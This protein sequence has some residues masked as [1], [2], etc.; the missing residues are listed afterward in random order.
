MLQHITLE[1]FTFRV[2]LTC[3]CSL[4]RSVHSPDGVSEH[5]EIKRPRRGN[6]I[7]SASI[8][9]SP[10]PSNHVLPTTLLI[11]H[12]SLTGYR[13][14]ADVIARVVKKTFA[15]IAGLLRLRQRKPCHYDKE[16][17]R[18]ETQVCCVLIVLSVCLCHL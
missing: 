3:S 13:S 10:C 11:K 1:S 9:N 7:Y 8:Q 4:Q 6:W 14:S 18:R 5:L 15:G 12:D 2:E 16:R 17:D